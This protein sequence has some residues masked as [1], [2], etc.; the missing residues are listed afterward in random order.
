MARMARAVAPGIPHHITQRGNRRQATFFCEEDYEAYLEIM[1]DWCAR[2]SVKIWAYCLMPNHV[3]LIGVPKSEDALRLA[4]GEAHR[5]DTKRINF[6]EGWRRV[7]KRIRGAARRRT[8]LVGTTSWCGYHLFW[9]WWEIGGNSFPR[10][11]RRRMSVSFGL[12]SAR[13]G[14]LEMRISLIVWRQPPVECCEGSNR[15]GRR[16]KS[17]NRNVV[18][19]NCVYYF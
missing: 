13:G 15:G 14:L 5:R 19:L 9:I 16:G 12:T 18:P 10:R 4:I 2:S 11:S 1:A 6:R 7:R 8:W 3:H 17:K